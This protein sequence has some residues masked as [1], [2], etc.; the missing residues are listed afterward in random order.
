MQRR[1]RTWIAVGVLFTLGNIA[2]AVYAGMM[3]EMRHAG[4][5]VV[6]TVVGAYVTSLIAA[7]RR[8]STASQELAA[9]GVPREL[10]SRLGSLEHSLD[11]MAVE[12]ERIGEG[13]R[14]MTRLFAE[15]GER[16]K[17]TP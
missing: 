2:G 6:L 12:V 8:E 1:S 14:F 3:G 5:H 15:R 11:A 16:D 17:E 4:L 7:R 9:A 10:S 13:Q